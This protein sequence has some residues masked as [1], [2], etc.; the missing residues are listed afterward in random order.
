M[1]LQQLQPISTLDMLSQPPL[2]SLEQRS[3]RL[4][5]CP[6]VLSPIQQGTPSD[7]PA[8]AAGS[9]ETSLS[10]LLATS[11]VEGDSPFAPTVLG[12]AVNFGIDLLQTHQPQS[13][14]SDYESIRLKVQ[15]AVDDQ[16]SVLLVQRPGFG[17]TRLTLELLSNDTLTIFL[18][19][20]TA[21][22]DQVFPSILLRAVG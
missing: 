17:K 1:S 8:L 13:A 15:T 6:P 7:N 9:R 20:T 22:R 21:L 2:D 4:Y 16:S 5:P 11:A 19:P 3:E 12:D 18:T 14:D 10:S